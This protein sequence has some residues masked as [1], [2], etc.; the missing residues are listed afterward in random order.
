MNT[1]AKRLLALFFAVLIMTVL[2]VTGMGARMTVDEIANEQIADLTEYVD[3]LVL[4]NGAFPMNKPSVS[5]FVTTQLETIDGVAPEVY[6]KWPSG[7]IVPYFSELAILGALKTSPEQAKAPTERFI[8]WY[9]SHLNDKESDI[10]GVD[11]TVYDYYCFVDPADS[12]HIIEVTLR[13]LYEHQYLDKP[14]SNPNDYDSTDSYAACFIR[15]LYEYYKNYGGDFLADKKDSVLR[16]LNALKSTYVPKLGLTG[17]KPNYMVCYLMDNC[18]VYDGL[19]AASKLFDELYGDK[20]LANELAELADTVKAS[21]EKHLWSETDGAYYPYVFADGVK[22]AKPNLDVFYP[23]ATA[24]LFAI[25][26]DLIEPTGERAKKLYEDFNARFGTKEKGW[27]WLRTGD[28]FPWASIS[29]VAAKMQDYE[30]LEIFIQMIRSTF[31]SKSY[32][33]PF[34]NSE[35]GAMLN[36]LDTYTNSTYYQETYST[37]DDTASDA[38]SNPESNDE[39]IAESNPESNATQTPAKQSNQWK[40]LLLGGAAAAVAAGIA[41]L[42]IKK[43]KK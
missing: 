5:G 20:A 39:S 42:L 27:Q 38:E 4:E 25:S 23:D 43:K 9:I 10:N 8:G 19:V 21:I 40:Y 24:Q 22:P 12:G 13:K 6:T 28:A 31:K 29:G 34:Y 30:R 36:M 3:G 41:V 11:G 18:E 32:A 33:Y 35:A 1:L 14:S 17:A 15:V 7:K 26:Y 37:S 16:I 2:P